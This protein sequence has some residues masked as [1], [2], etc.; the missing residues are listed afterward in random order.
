MTSSPWVSV[1]ARTLAATSAPTVEFERRAE[2]LLPLRV[3][4]DALARRMTFPATGWSAWTFAS[5]GVGGGLPTWAEIARYP[6]GELA[7]LLL[8]SVDATRNQISSASRA[9]SRTRGA[10]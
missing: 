7:G 9:A 5:C 1:N 4:L 6:D 10:S 3:Q 2:D 8:L